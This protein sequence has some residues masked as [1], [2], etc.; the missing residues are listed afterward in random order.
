M[1][2]GSLCIQRKDKI[3]FREEFTVTVLDRSQKGIKLPLD[4][5]NFYLTVLENDTEV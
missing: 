3:A 4:I 5:P 1:I 2:L